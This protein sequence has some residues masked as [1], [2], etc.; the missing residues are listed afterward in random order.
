M[1]MYQVPELQI[2]E[3]LN[4]SLLCLFLI[5]VQLP[6]EAIDATHIEDLVCIDLP[7]I[8]AEK[9]VRIIILLFGEVVTSKSFNIGG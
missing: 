1:V 3:G 5:V 2:V 6:P 9:M 8:A 4:I 7:S